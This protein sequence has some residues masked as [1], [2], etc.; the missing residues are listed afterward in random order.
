ML[1]DGALD[2]GRVNNTQLIVLFLVQENYILPATERRGRPRV[3]PNIVSLTLNSK[4]RNLMI[5][6]YFMPFIF[7]KATYCL[8]VF[9]HPFPGNSTYFT[10]NVLYPIASL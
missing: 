5:R 1:V 10:Y 3:Q 4:Q 8:W 9:G 7:I 2:G 6:S